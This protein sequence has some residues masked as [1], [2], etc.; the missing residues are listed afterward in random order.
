MDALRITI[1]SGKGGT[2]KTTVAVNLAYSLAAAGKP[3]ILL[4]CDVEEP[5]DHL[6]VGPSF[7]ASHPVT[8][9]KPVLDED[10]CTL[11][12]R[13]AAACAFN[14]IAVMRKKLLIFPE[15]CHA[16]GVCTEVCPEGALREEAFPIGTVRV[17]STGSA[18]PEA[19]FRFA[20]GTLAVGESQAPAV[21]RAVKRLGGGG[22]SSGVA[23]PGEPSTGDSTSQTVVLI[24]A[25]PGTAC[26]VVEAMRGSDVVLLVTEPTPFGLHD[27]KLA[28]SLS[29]QL[30]IPTA[31]VINR[32]VGRDGLIEEYCRRVGVPI[33][34]RIAFRRE[35]AEVYSVGGLLAREDPALQGLLLQILDRARALAGGRAAARAGRRDLGWQSQLTRR[36]ADSRSGTA[37]APATSDDQ[38]SVTVRREI[39]VVSGKGGT[40]K[41]TVTACLAVLASDK[42]LADTDV[43]AADLHLVL[44]P[45]TLEA[46][47]FSGG[48]SFHIDPEVCTACGLCEQK[49]RFEAI[50][51]APTYTIDPAACEGCGLCALVCPVE[52]VFTRDAINGRTFVSQ[53]PYGPMVHA[54]LG[55][56][57]ENSGKLV[58]EVRRLAGRLAD[59]TSAPLVLADGPP[60]VG[61]PVIASIT[62]LDQVLVVTEPT[63]SGVHDLE[64]VLD[65]AA[66]FRVPAGVII[67]KADLNPAAGAADP[68]GRLRAGRTGNRRDPVRRQGLRSAHGGQDRR[69]VRGRSGCGGAAANRRPH[70]PGLAGILSPVPCTFAR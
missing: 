44:R 70:R 45:L 22:V 29:L 62:D 64:R 58:T 20:D 1:A 33:L 19:P 21:V 66:H 5:N 16:C 57:E 30:R 25:S 10:R 28:V 55:I 7:S 26:P 2:G 53:T 39:G 18:F 48:K 47:P 65:L 41:T 31:V 56:G 61:C 24:D 69:R 37:S 11:C 32:S 54:R 40:G 43:D 3:V 67:N 60:G 35:Y 34:G 51:H 52:A 14:A 49:C 59:R 38:G 8:V 68:N 42:V 27:L 12:G 63:V 6:F 13:C 15:L 50:S 9:L 4:D 17:G 46:A 23:E 36:A